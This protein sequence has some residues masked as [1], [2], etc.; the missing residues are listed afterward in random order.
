MVTRF[1]NYALILFGV[2][3]LLSI[4]LIAMQYTNEVNWSTGDFA[5]MGIML[6]AVGLGLEYVLRKTKRRWIWAAIII[7]LFLL[8]WGERAVGIFGTPFAGS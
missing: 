4:P 7:L 8:V 6:L 2:I 5:I 1:R 3:I